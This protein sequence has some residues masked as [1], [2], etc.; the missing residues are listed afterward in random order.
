MIIRLVNAAKDIE[1]AKAQAYAKALES[2]DVNLISGGL[3]SLLGL[4]IGPEQG[5]GL[6][7]MVKSLSE[8]LG[9]ETVHKL[10]KAAEDLTK[11]E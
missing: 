9:P 2:A 7:A 5:A 11:T 10:K 4:P 8:V 6:G 1:I 3:T